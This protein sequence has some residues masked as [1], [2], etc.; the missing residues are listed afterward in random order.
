M[1]YLTVPSNV[2]AVNS[3]EPMTPAM[4]AVVWEI[5]NAI[6]EQ[7]GV[8][9]CAHD[10]DTEGLA[11]PLPDTKF[12]RMESPIWLT[13]RAARLRGESGRSD[14]VWLRECL[15]RLCGI[16]L[17]GADGGSPWGGVLIAEWH[18]TDA[19]QNVHLLIP[20]LAWRAFDTP[21]TFAKIEASAAHR[22][23]GHGRRLYAILADKTRLDRPNWTFGINEMRSLLGVAHKPSYNRWSDFRVRVLDPAVQAINDHG[24]ITVK[25]VPIKEGRSVARIHFEWSWKDHRSAAETA[26]ENDRHSK[27]RRKKQD[28]VDA[29]PM[30]D[31]APIEIEAAEVDSEPSLLG[32]EP[33]ESHAL[34]WWDSLTERTR[35]HFRRKIGLRYVKDWL[36]GGTEIVTRR[37]RDFAELTYEQHLKHGVKL[38]TNIQRVGRAPPGEK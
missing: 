36:A 27:V 37:E 3:Y 33:Q 28:N 18:I 14:N 8:Y 29:P 7:N 30:T 31:N 32:P 25:M 1:R 11:P 19:G 10:H 26:T 22:L 38:P 12:N 9:I 15:D 16:R 23:S 5:A 2:I 4:T 13:V 6:D 34:V 35:D 17:T 20:P 21:S 24:T